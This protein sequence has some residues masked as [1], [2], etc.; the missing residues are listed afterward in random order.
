[1]TNSSQIHAVKIREQSCLFDEFE[2]TINGVCFSIGIPEAIS[3]FEQGIVFNFIHGQFGILTL[4]EIVNAFTLYSANK[5]KFK[6]SHFGKFDN[7]FIGNVLSSYLEHLANERSKNQIYEPEPMV[8]VKYT[9]EEGLKSYEFIKGVFEKDKRPPFIASWTFAFNWM[10]KEKMIV[11]EDFEIEAIRNVVHNEMMEEVKE[12]R[13]NR[14]DVSNLLQSME[15]GRGVKYEC[16][17]KCVI[18][19]FTNLI[20]K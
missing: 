3:R 1:M 8:R 9:P 19:Y 6:D 17:K 2:T 5:L 4:E 10:W 13:R 16:H 7:K 14:K 15:T 11:L 20:S 12:R 18:E